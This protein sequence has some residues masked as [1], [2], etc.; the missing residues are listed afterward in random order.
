MK[1]ICWHYSLFRSS[2][3]QD[4]GEEELVDGK[5]DH[6]LKGAV[7][8]SIQLSSYEIVQWMNIKMFCLAM[9]SQIEFLPVWMLQ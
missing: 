3:S 2:K 6:K 9:F 1:D 5:T 7:G 4:S 8:F